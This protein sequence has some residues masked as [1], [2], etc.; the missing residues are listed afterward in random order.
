[1]PPSSALLPPGIQYPG[2]GIARS[3]LGW[4]IGETIYVN[5]YVWPED[6]VC[7]LMAPYI[8]TTNMAHVDRVASGP[9]VRRLELIHRLQTRLLRRT[10][11]VPRIR[12]PRIAAAC[13]L[14]ASGPAFAAPALPPSFVVE[15]VTPGATFD[16]PT[17]IAFLPGGRLLVAEKAGVVY[18]VTNGAKSATPLWTRT[19]EVLNDGDR[20]LLALAVDPNYVSNHYIY[21]MYSVDPDSNGVDTSPTDAFGRLVRYTVS[22]TDSNTVDYSQRAVLM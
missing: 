7:M 13:F 3:V 14:L 11:R 22:F 21:L 12:L 6:Y 15:S 17:A 4:R 2:T 1:M 16:T 18:S 9:A 10:P 19:N 8:N 20:G 5:A